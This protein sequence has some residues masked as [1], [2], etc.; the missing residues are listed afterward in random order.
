MRLLASVHASFWKQYPVFTLVNYRLSSVNQGALLT[1]SHGQVSHSSW[2]I[3][4]FS[5]QNLTF[6][7]SDKMTLELLSPTKIAAIDS[8]AWG[9]LLL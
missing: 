3:Y 5:L 1:L 7:Q 9:T 2:V 8:A 4:M 6:E